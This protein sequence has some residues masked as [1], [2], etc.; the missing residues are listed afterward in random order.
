MAKDTKTLALR[1]DP[2]LHARLSIIAE[3]AQVSV[4]DLVRDAIDDRI[5]ALADDPQVVARADVA[6]QAIR[7]AARAREAALQDM[8]GTAKPASTTAGAKAT[9]RTR[10]TSN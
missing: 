6:A 4:T 9:P 3:L 10:K 2:E 5:K 7:D 1:L 8:F